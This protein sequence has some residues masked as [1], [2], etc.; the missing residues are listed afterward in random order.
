MLA[1]HVPLMA[2]SCREIQINISRKPLNLHRKLQYLVDCG[3]KM[4]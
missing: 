1:Y 3:V 4:C 2:S